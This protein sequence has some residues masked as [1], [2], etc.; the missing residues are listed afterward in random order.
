MTLLLAGPLTYCQEDDPGNDFEDE[1]GNTDDAVDAPI[2]DYVGWLAGGAVVL[3]LYLTVKQKDRKKR[4]N[5]F[6]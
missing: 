5:K 3:G 2:G 6:Y 1:Y 4:K